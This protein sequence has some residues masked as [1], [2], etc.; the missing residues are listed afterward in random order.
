MENAL[1][2]KYPL[3]RFLFWYIAGPPSGTTKELVDWVLGPQGQNV[4]KEVGF[5]PLKGNDAP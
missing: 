4:V 2:N 1:S 3:S 5:Y